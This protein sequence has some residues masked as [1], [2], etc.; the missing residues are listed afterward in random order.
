MLVQREIIPAASISRS[1][2]YLLQC[3]YAGS[4]E[5]YSAHLELKDNIINDCSELH[6]YCIRL[7]LNPPLLGLL[8]LEICP[9]GSHCP[10]VCLLTSSSILQYQYESKVD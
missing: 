9:S 3:N 2:R 4:V 1:P 7:H 5:N 6:C 8:V 10:P